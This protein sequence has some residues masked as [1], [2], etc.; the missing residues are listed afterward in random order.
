M[1][2]HLFA[3]SY[4]ECSPQLVVDEVYC[5]RLIV[6]ILFLPKCAA[7]AGHAGATLALVLCVGWGPSDEMIFAIRESVLHAVYYCTADVV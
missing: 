3:K 7:I 6:V 1:S 4:R 5:R 2:V